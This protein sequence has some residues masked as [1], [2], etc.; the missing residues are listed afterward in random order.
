MGCP[1]GQACPPRLRVGPLSTQRPAFLGW[2]GLTPDSCARQGF[3]SRAPGGFLGSSVPRM[4]EVTVP[5]VAGQPRGGRRG[6][7]PDCVQRQVSGESRREVVPAW[8]PAGGA[9][10][11]ELLVP[12]EGGSLPPPRVQAE[13]SGLPGQRG[14]LRCPSLSWVREVLGQ[15]WARRG[16][17]A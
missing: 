17:G 3:R 13:G 6:V 10:A 7:R 2:L 12:R 4:W 16:R 14:G 1:A 11:E 9:W 8:G 5:M 15:A